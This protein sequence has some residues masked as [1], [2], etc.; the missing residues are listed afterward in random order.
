MIKLHAPIRLLAAGAAA[1]ALVACTANQDDIPRWMQQQRAQAVPEVQPLEP[2][3]RYLPL[4]YTE[5]VSADPFSSA[6]LS[7]LLSRTRGMRPGG[8]T[9]LIDAELN[10]RRQ[11]LE[12]YPLDVMSMVGSLDR[13][14]QR[15][16]LV[17]V[18]KLLH[19]VSTG[20]YLGQNYGL[21]TEISEGQVT[22][23]E[24]VQDA[25]GEWVKRP[26]TLQLQESKK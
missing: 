10:R 11:P 22:L 4:D 21:V 23:R 13:R 14:G 7:A 18:D 1:A 12:A 3:R 26:A 2:P 17:R 16:A 20:Q 24:I 15:V 6:R 9:S 8:G 5:S 19:Q 25:A